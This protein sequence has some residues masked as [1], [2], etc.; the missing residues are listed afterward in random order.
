MSSL[1]VTEKLAKVFNDVVFGG[2]SW[3]RDESKI[4]FVG[5][6]PEIAAFKNPFE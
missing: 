6:A 5:E 4:T 3:S 2:I 1:K